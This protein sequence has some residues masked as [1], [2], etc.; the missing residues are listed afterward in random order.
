M[1]WG[2]YSV[3]YV[4]IFPISD[5]TKYNLFFPNFYNQVSPCFLL[6][7]SDIGKVHPYADI[8]ESFFF[9]LITDIRFCINNIWFQCINFWYSTCYY[10]LYSTQT[11]SDYAE[12]QKLW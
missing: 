12:K 5:I 10:L 1:G 2:L 4:N 6:L 8:E 9:L 3:I 11:Q 7:I